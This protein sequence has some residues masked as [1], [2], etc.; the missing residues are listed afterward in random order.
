MRAL[1]CTDNVD[2]L[3]G[4][5]YTRRKD[6]VITYRFRG[7]K[8]KDGDIRRYVVEVDKIIG[9]YATYHDCP[10]SHH[11]FPRLQDS[12]HLTYLLNFYRVRAYEI[13]PI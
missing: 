4:A 11:I 12:L 1:I 13:N 3:R 9:H 7:Q 6:D 8:Y 2:D 10:R 5:V